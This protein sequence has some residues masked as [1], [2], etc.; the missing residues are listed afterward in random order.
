MH[1]RSIIFVITA[2]LVIAA[3]LVCVFPKF[4]P[5]DVSLQATKLNEKGETLGTYEIH[6]RGNRL[7]YLF[8]DSA[9]DVSITSFDDLSGF[10][11]H[12]KIETTPGTDICYVLYSA[13]NSATD[14]VA[15]FEI[16]FSPDMDRWIFLNTTDK[17]Y[18]VA[19]VNEQYSIQ[20]LIEYFRPMIP[21]SW[22]S[23]P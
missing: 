9:L 6:I 2:V 21:S 13:S 12:G 10:K 15:F 20:E 5:V 14:D 22:I 8:A 17:V 23:S 18:Y 16:G 11:C 1:K 7:D 4:T 19:S 3:I